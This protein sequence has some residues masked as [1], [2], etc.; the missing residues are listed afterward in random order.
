MKNPLHPWLPDQECECEKLIAAIKKKMADLEAYAAQ[1]DIG[2]GT[3]GAMAGFP[4]AR[5]F[6]LARDG[7]YQLLDE[8]LTIAGN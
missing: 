5:A 1:D 4:T 6:L 8:L 7:Q 3:V 2:I